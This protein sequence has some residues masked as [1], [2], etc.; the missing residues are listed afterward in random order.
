M[1]KFTRKLGTPIIIVVMI[2]FIAFLS[3]AAFKQHRASKQVPKC[4]DIK[5]LEA[6]NLETKSLNEE[7]MEKKLAKTY[8]E[9]IKLTIEAIINSVEIGYDPYLD[10]R[11]CNAALK[12]SVKS[13]E[14]SGMWEKTLNYNIYSK[15]SGGFEVVPSYSILSA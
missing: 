12:L 15:S 8:N 1:S 9:T 5:I 6:L 2:S 14:G 3:F 7:V 13:K 4:D 11:V 10:T